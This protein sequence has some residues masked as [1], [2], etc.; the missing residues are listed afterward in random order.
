[1][2]IGGWRRRTRGGALKK[3]NQLELGRLKNTTNS[4]GNKV[5]MERITL[6]SVS[7]ERFEVYL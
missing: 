7:S 4:R 2:G 5:N 3:N 1:L 6:K